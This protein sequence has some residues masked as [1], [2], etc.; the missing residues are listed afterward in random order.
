MALMNVN[1]RNLVLVSYS[2]VDATWL[3]RLKTHLQPLERQ[4]AIEV[5]DDRRIGTGARWRDEIEGALARTKVAVLLVSP[6]FLASEFIARHELPDLM[7]AEKGL[8]TVIWIPVRPSNYAATELNDYQ[9]ALDPRRTLAEMEEAEADRALVGVSEQI[10]KAYQG[11]SIE[12]ERPQRRAA[13]GSRAWFVVALAGVALAAAGAW[14]AMN[15]TPTVVP[16]PER[17][18]AGQPASSVPSPAAPP[19]GT[20]VIHG[21]VVQNVGPGGNAVV[22][23]QVNEG[24]QPQPKRK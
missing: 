10:V 9:A 1:G 20:T 23:N 7:S 2:H 17:P 15:R 4:G 6:D 21:D 14:L 5:W 22:G 16:G 8:T 18:E 12:V 13:A 11:G 3:E 19:S 24:P